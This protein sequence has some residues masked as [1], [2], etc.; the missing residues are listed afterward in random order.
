MEERKCG[1]LHHQY[2]QPA[3]RHQFDGRTSLPKT[4]TALPLTAV[5]N[6]PKS[7]QSTFQG[8]TALCTSSPVWSPVPSTHTIWGSGDTSNNSHQRTHVTVSTFPCCVCCAHFCVASHSKP[9]VNLPGFKYTVNA[10]GE[11]NVEPCP[12]NTYNL[13]LRRQRTCW[14]CP[15][16]HTTNE[17]TGAT[18]VSQCGE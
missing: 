13:G 4:P 10:M 7:P 2:I 3:S 12:I 5:C 11:P 18:D 1:A 14:P 9:A 17:L 16:G 15:S 8:S 6:V